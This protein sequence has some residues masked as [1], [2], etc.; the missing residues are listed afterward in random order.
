MIGKSKS[1]WNGVAKDKI[2]D[3]EVYICD[4]C[5][6]E[7]E[8]YVTEFALFPPSG[9]IINDGEIFICNDCS[10][11]YVYDNHN[12]FN[13]I[14]L[15]KDY[16]DNL[17]DFNKDLFETIKYFLP[18]ILSLSRKAISKRLREKILQILEF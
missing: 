17:I 6:K 7:Y 4:N 3:C 2:I 15:Y 11:K 9:I 14:S 12:L 8:F 5:K 18:N 13:I 10:L 1:Y 16:R